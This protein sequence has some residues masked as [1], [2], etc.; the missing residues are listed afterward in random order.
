MA[1]SGVGHTPLDTRR[2]LHL[3]FGRQ[4][5]SEWPLISSEKHSGANFQTDTKARRVVPA[6]VVVVVKVL[7]V[8]VVA[9]A[10]GRRVDKPKKARC[11][12]VVEVKKHQKAS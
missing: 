5:Y 9:V 8:A 6:V 11:P 10:I 12:V 4:G 1:W 3:L 2:F 7:G